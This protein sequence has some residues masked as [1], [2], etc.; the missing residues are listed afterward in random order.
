MQ[1]GA[2][3]PPPPEANLAYQKKGEESNGVIRLIDMIINDVEKENQVMELEEKQ[4]QK[5]YERLMDLS[6]KKRAED[7][8]SM[9]DKEG[10]LAD[11]TEEL[12]TSKENLKNKKF[13]L[14]N[15]V[16]LLAETHAECDWLIKYYD[17]RK[18]ARTG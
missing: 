2:A 1:S 10:A 15:T 18:E 8:K 3:P 14:M 12:V 9:T 5:D 7:S 17:A 13:E 11:T 6:G 4:A 16:K